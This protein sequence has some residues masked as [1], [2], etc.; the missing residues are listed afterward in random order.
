M[1]DVISETEEQVTGDGS[2]RENVLAHEL[3]DETV[4]REFTGNGH[5]STYFARMDLGRL[6][7][8]A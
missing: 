4:M 5:N 2:T 7:E 1:T 8:G 3:A 6:V